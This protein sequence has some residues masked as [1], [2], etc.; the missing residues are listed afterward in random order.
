MLSPFYSLLSGSAPFQVICKLVIGVLLS[1]GLALRATLH[2]TAYKCRGRDT[3]FLS[4]TTITITEYPK[5]EP[6]PK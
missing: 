6:F 2:L 3:A 5:I 4:P 1:A